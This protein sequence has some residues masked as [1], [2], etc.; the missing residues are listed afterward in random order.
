MK[1]FLTD[2]VAPALRRLGL[3][4]SQ[5][6]FTQPS[7][8]HYINVG[9]NR[10]GN[11]NAAIVQFGANVQVIARDE[12]RREAQRYR[13]GDK[14]NPKGTYGVGIEGGLGGWCVYA[15]APLNELA[16]TVVPQMRDGIIDARRSAGLD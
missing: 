15:G 6:S 8:T 12:W 13:L 3:R 7:D 2:Y 16:S 5:Q 11:S 10:S 4:G 1:A 14:P 9:I